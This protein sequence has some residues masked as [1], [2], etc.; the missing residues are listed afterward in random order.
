MKTQ[1]LCSAL[2]LLLASTSVSWA[3]ASADEAARI[4][5]AFQTYVGTEP[6]VV[7]VVPAGDAYEITLDA[8]PYIQ[9]IGESGV[10]SSIDPVKFKAVPNGDGTWAVTASGPFKATADA[11]GKF[12]MT[13]EA[14]DIQ[15][16]G[17]Y[18]E[19][20][21]S[22]LESSYNVSKFNISQSNTDPTRKITTSGITAIDSIVGLGTTTDAGGGLADNMGSAT[23]TGMVTSTNIDM[24]P[25]A[26][27]GGMP[28]LNYVA[29]I[30]SLK[31]ATQLKGLTAKP[32]MELMAFFV[33]H[34]SKDLM[35]KDQAILKEKLLAALPLFAAIDSSSTFDNMTID[36]SMGQFGIA[37]GGSSVGLNGAVKLGRF[38][39]GF[40]FKDLKLPDG[41]PLPPWSNGLIPT[42]FKIGFDVSGYDA[43][44]PVRKFI[45]EM[46]ITK[47]EPVP[48]GSEAAYMAAFLPTNTFKLVIPP[49]EITSSVYSLTYEGTSDISLAGLPKV[50]AKFRMTG[51][52]KVIAQLQQAAADPMAQQALAGLFA[53]KGMGK[54]DGDA[55]VWEVNMGPDGKLLINGTDI[56][57]MLG[58]A[59]PPAQ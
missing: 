52:E 44:T 5:A 34:P 30:G 43:E 28:N 11:P 42:K 51:M 41:L 9:K 16:T 33:S 20:L 21:F 29:K 13:L 6:G 27:A 55:T 19:K 17:N 3:A 15:F 24:P 26:G 36:T 40:E 1:K 32:V 10:T 45:S 49:S 4:Q 18:S 31:T 57:A 46:D 47:V 35:V 23:F 7:A 22:F 50:S 56:S 8:M 59:A 12:T 39:E 48:P 2:F 38:A 54:A 37:G 25:D 58:M 53:A 14:A